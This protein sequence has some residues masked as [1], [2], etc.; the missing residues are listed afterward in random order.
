MNCNCKCGCYLVDC[1]QITFLTAEII[2]KRPYY[3]DAVNEQLIEAL[4]IDCF[5]ELCNEVSN[6]R[7]EA[8][9]VN[10]ANANDDEV[11]QTYIYNWTVI[12]TATF[13]RWY[14]LNAEYQY[15]CQT[16]L[17]KINVDCLIADTLDSNNKYLAVTESDL[18]RI[19]N[20]KYQQIKKATKQL[21]KMQEWQQAVETC[22]PKKQTCGCKK[23]CNCCTTK[24]P[25]SKIFV[26]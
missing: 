8:E 25:K 20:F 18:K 24:K 5:N 7:N 21:L 10:D 14:S 3:L 13:K 22:N 4:G 17:A 16:T 15:L 26:G 19:T 9:T 11:W 12:L 1:W 2:E 6:A 23:A